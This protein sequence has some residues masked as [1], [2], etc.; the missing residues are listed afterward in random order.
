[1]QFSRRRIARGKKV[2]GGEGRGMKEKGRKEESEE[3]RGSIKTWKALE[4]A[5]EAWNVSGK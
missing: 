3:G 5:R 1:M 2:V 4:N